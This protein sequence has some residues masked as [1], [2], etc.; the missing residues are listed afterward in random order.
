M[1]THIQVVITEHSLDYRLINQYFKFS[2]FLGESFMIR[3]LLVK[4][5]NKPHDPATKFDSK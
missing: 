1:K 2:S 4:S 3:L 5:F